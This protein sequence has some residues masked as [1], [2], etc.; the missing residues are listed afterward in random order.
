MSHPT[1]RARP[2]LGVMT[3]VADLEDRSRQTYRYVRII[4][5]LPAVWLLLSIATVWIFRGQVLHSISDYYGGPLRDVFVGGLM[6]FGICMIAYKGQSKLEE[7][8]LNFAGFNAFLV[9]LVPN[10]F[11]DL[12]SEAFEAEQAG[13]SVTVGSA[14]LRQNLQIAVGVFLLVALVFVVVDG[15]VLNWHEFRWPEQST[16]A[17]IAIIASFAAEVVLL[18]FVAMMVSGNDQVGGAWVYTIVHFTAAALLVVNLSLAAASNA[19]AGL[20]KSQVVPI[21]N[22]A[23]PW[24][25]QVIT[26]A[27]WVGIVIGG[28]AILRDVAYAIIVTEV[29]EIVLFLAFWVGATGHEWRRPSVDPEAL[30][31]AS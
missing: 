29:W 22:G 10:S 26:V 9:A 12:L 14:E 24:Y 19:F 7:Y 28:I 27:M 31:V 25:F 15:F 4:V 17:N 23:P 6:A 11:A 2:S 21:F 3:D 5:V 16:L 18:V 8:A 20:H 13:V 30:E 1:G